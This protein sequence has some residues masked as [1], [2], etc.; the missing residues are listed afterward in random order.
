MKL[1][2]EQLSRVLSDHEAGHLRRGGGLGN[3]PRGCLVQ[4]AI[5]KWCGYM[6]SPLYLDG[7]GDWFDTYYLPDDTTDD[8]LF[9][10]EGAGLA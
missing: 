5:N 9:K 7:A 3:T 1:T 4:V 10:L 6:L 8:F 2:D